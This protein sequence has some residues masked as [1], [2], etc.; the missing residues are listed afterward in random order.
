MRKIPNSPGWTRCLPYVPSQSPELSIRDRFVDLSTVCSSVVLPTIVCEFLHGIHSAFFVVWLSV[1]SMLVQCA[2]TVNTLPVLAEYKVWQKWGRTPVLR[3]LKYLTDYQQR[4][5]S[6][7]TSW[8]MWKSV[9]N[10]LHYSAPNTWPIHTLQTHNQ[11]E[12][13]GNWKELVTQR[14]Q[15]VGK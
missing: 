8:A 2:I 5:L 10:T 12:I 7:Q 11:K 4:R 9:I 15:F 13:L 14:W 3:P 6:V 1:C